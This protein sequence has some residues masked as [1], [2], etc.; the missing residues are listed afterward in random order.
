[1]GGESNAA[2]RRAARHGDGWYS[3]NRLPADLGE[4][5]ARLDELLAAEGRSR[6]DLELTVSPYFH[7]VDAAAIEAYREHGVDRLVVLC[8]AFD[9]DGLRAQLDDLVANVLEPSRA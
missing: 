9:V 6:A 5:L 2:L 7:T 1:M 8:L 3:F 4:P